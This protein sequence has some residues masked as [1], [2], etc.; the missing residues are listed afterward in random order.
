MEV[1]GDAFLIRKWN[2]SMLVAVIDG[3][4]HGQFAHKA[5]RSALTYIE[6][7]YD[8]PLSDIF[9]GVGRVCRSTRGVVMALVRFDWARGIVSIGNIGNIE[10]R[11]FGTDDVPMIAT[12]RG[13]IGSASPVP[14][15][16]EHPWD[17]RGVMV[18]HSDGIRTQWSWS[19]FSAYQHEPPTV[20]AG[21]MLSK[22]ARDTD[23]ATLV[24]IKKSLKDGN[25]A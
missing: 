22:L 15:I 1:N 12:R 7:H 3:L 23:D 8:Q 25:I 11:V 18:V 6:K 20:L 19:E 9:R 17:E 13:I 16:R 10:I 4:G 5:S 24:V 2:E 14:L 21:R